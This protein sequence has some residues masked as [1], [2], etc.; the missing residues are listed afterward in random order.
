VRAAAQTPPWIRRGCRFL[1]SMSQSPLVRGAQS[2]I[3]RDTATV[4]VSETE[5]ILKCR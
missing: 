1:F 2:G 3:R 4:M 5:T